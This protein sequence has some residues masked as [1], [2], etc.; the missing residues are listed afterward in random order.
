MDPYGQ[1][2]MFNQQ[3]YQ[4]QYQRPK[5]EV[6]RVNGENGAKAYQLMPNSSILLLDE[7]APIVWLKTT[8]GAGYPTITG[9]TISPLESKPDTDIS[10]L[11]T[12]I[13]KLE[14]MIADGAS[15]SNFTN[16]KQQRPNQE[17]NR[18]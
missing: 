11:E 17:S 14:R 2:Q 3:P 5:Q 18:S 1:F 12:I 16:A 6:I 4:Y 8:D 13:E 15:K 9:Y 7:T 10:A